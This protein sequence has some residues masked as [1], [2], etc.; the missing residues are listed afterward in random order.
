MA[1]GCRGCVIYLIC[2]TFAPYRKELSAERSKVIGLFSNTRQ[3]HIKFH[4]SCTVLYTRTRQSKVFTVFHTVHTR[5]SGV[6]VTAVLM[7][8]FQ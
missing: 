2:L 7:P 6:V 5:I 3:Y 1:V 8:C 4:F